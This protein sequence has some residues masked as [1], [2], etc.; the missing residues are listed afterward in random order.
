MNN[1]LLPSG[2]ALVPVLQVV[3]AVPLR[4]VVAVRFVALQCIHLV[5]CT[6]G[7]V[8]LI[9]CLIRVDPGKGITPKAAENLR[10]GCLV[11]ESA[12]DVVIVV[13]N[14]LTFRLMRVR[15]RYTRLCCQAPGTRS[16]ALIDQSTHCVACQEL[17]QDQ[18]K[19]WK[20]STTM[21]SLVQEAAKND[22]S[23][24]VTHGYDGGLQTK[25]TLN[26]RLLEIHKKMQL[27]HR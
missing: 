16:F 22:S 23:D 13:E 25:L 20:R 8:S 4:P 6:P 2:S 18:R 9:L 12:A 27:L 5:P 14:G 10:H 1:Y 15:C 17:Q 21:T 19:I 11:D 26:D 24:T 3:P 7:H